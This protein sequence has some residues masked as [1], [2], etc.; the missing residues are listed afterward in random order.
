MSMCGKEVGLLNINTSE[1]DYKFK[2]IAEC[3]RFFN[4][5]TPTIF[6]SIRRN[7]IFRRKYKIIK[8]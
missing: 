7:R 5:F 2:S 4:V 6:E 3:A 8:I 1:I